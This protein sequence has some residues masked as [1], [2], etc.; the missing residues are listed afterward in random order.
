MV[1]LQKGQ[2]ILTNRGFLM[3]PL[4]ANIPNQQG[5]DSRSSDDE[6]I[7]YC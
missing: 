1:T 2:L 5:K 3:F 4:S 7:R 6:V